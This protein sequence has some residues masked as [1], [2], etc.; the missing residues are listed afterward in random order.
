MS[1]IPI[2]RIS[3][4]TDQTAPWEG[5]EFVHEV[6][7]DALIEALR[8]CFPRYRNL[9]ERKH[10]AII[11][12]LTAELAEMLS[13]NTRHASAV[14]TN[15]ASGPEV[16]L[17]DVRGSVHLHNPLSAAPSPASSECSS[18]PREDIN[19]P[20]A[21]SMPITQPSFIDPAAATH[22]SQYVF[23][24]VDGRTMQQKSKRRMTAEER[25]EYKETRKRGACSKCKRL[26]GKVRMMLE[27][28]GVSVL[29]RPSVRI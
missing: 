24:A 8:T 20:T 16:A 29:M 6:G 12:F 15:G 23:H 19:N 26:K 25:L 2:K 11:Q 3:P 10:A 13:S 21:S 14:H 4:T 18:A 27:R 1:A 28:R 9:R 17:K 5:V 7:S 22:S